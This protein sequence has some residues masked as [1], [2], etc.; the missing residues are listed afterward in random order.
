MDIGDDRF[1]AVYTN[2]EYN[3][4]PAS[5][6]FKRTNNMESMIDEKIKRKTNISTSAKS[7]NTRKSNDDGDNVEAKSDNI[8]NSH[9]TMDP[10][11]VSKLDSMDNLIKSVISKSKLKFNNKK[12]KK[13]WREV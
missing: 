11:T 5:H 4:E 10:Q 1:S 8:D 2:P 3:I 12:N 13:K 9:A 7:S 6:E